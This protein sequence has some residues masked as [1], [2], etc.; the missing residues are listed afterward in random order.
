M[1]LVLLGGPG[2]GKGTQAQRLKE[3][4]GIVWISTGDVLRQEIAAGSA[5][6]V[7]VK[8]AVE[9]GDLVKDETIIK[10]M[11]QRL[12]QPDVA[13]GWLLD[14]YPR[15]AF[16]AEELDFLL[17]DLDQKLDRAIWLE[18]PKSVLRARSLARSRTDDHPEAI[19]RRIE[20]SYEQTLPMLDYYDYRQKLLRI[21]GNQP[22]EQ[23]WQSLQQALSTVESD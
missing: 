22:P 19:A 16:Q 10:L 8:A 13:S 15:T 6:G 23:V 17:E 12:Q 14:G 4:L 2:A 9:Q 7:Q 20:L 21:N 3:D 11:R 5:L 1:R 18:V